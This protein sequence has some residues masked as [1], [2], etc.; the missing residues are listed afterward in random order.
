MSQPSKLSRRTLL[1]TAGALL[2]R[3]QPARPE[4]VIIV[5]DGPVLANC[6]EFTHAWAACPEPKGTRTALLSGCF[7]HAGAPELGARY[8]TGPIAPRD[9]DIVVITSAAPGRVPL[10]IRHPRL[11][12]KPR[13]EDF[14]ISHVDVMPTLLGLS[15]LEIPGGL[16]GRDHSALLLDGH[17][18]RPE[19]IYAEGNLGLP[20]EWR[21]I[22]RGLD[23]I[24]FNRSLKITHL[25]N[26]GVDPREE[27]DLVDD[28]ASELKRAGLRA[29]LKE[30]I[31]RTEDRMDA[32]GLKRR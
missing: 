9:T 2:A 3:A 15:G 24:V 11:I 26:L 31:R 5:A 14:L 21:M 6:I 19:S 12:F 17:G 4:I 10:R 25:Y 30:W 1:G 7:P 27:E 23:R 28:P 32:S 20:A 8:V 22:V 16:H 13:E 18:A 29:L